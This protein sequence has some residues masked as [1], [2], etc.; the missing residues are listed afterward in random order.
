MVGALAAGSARVQFSAVSQL[1]VPAAAVLANFWRHHAA[2]GGGNG[3][4]SGGAG[5]LPAKG[6][7][8]V[9]NELQKNSESARQ[10]LAVACVGTLHAAMPAGVQQDPILRAGGQVRGLGGEALTLSLAH[11]QVL[12]AFMGALTQATL[13]AGAAQQPGGGPTEAVQNVATSAAALLTWLIACGDR[14]RKAGRPFLSLARTTFALLWALLICGQARGDEIADLLL[15]AIPISLQEE[16]LEGDAHV[17]LCVLCRAPRAAGVIARDGPCFRAVVQA[18]KRA[19]Q[20]GAFG[21]K[22]LAVMKALKP[23][24]R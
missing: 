18:A 13:A 11:T 6:E 7:G 1:L 9:S 8:E 24:D 15:P 5:A 3:V 21:D 10:V 23:Y 20:A 14:G 4:G 22:W 16:D 2:L 19:G 12:Q 17:L